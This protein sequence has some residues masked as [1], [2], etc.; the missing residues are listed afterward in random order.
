MSHACFT[1]AGQPR[2]APSDGRRAARL[3]PRQSRPGPPRR[4]RRQHLTPQ[5]LP[6]LAQAGRSGRSVGAAASGAVREG[7]PL[8]SS[9]LQELL[10][11]AAS[12][13][14]GLAAGAAA[15]TLVYLAGIRV[16]LAG[17]TWEGVLSSWVLG[18]LTYS[19]FGAGAYLIVCTYFLVGSLV[20]RP[21]GSVPARC[22][23]CAAVR[24]FGVA[25]AIACLSPSAG[26]CHPHFPGD[27][28]EAGAEAARGHRRGAVGAALAGAS[29]DKSCQAVS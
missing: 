7:Q 8:R 23:R 25:S 12:P 28:S 4:A 11:A 6:P 24:C 19:A 16:L 29:N 10:T 17:L 18:T 15:N 2:A 5:A 1:L 3:P 13:T 21:P 27:Q 22:A 20:S 9:L 14:P 26:A